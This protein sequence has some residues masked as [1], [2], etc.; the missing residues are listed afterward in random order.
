MTSVLMDIWRSFRSLPLWVQI[1]VGVIL[2]PVNMSTI[3]ML[4]QENGKGWFILTLSMGGMVPNLYL[5]FKE[6]GFSK[7][8]AFSHLVFWIPLLYFLFIWIGLAMIMVP[9]DKLFIWHLVILF[10]VNAISICFD[11]KDSWQW[12]KGDRK[13]AS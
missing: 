6:R 1:W 3:F 11:L 2:V 10:V 5:M 8:M 7:A 13:I 4:L 12:L 9:E